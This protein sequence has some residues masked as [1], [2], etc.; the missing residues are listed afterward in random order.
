MQCIHVVHWMQRIDK[1]FS[2][3]PNYFFCISESKSL[4]KC[5][6][7]PKLGNMFSVS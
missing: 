4:L 2:F 6:E 5:V 1:K 7:A 3:K